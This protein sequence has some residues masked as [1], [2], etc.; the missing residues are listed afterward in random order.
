M[1]AFKKSLAEAQSTTPPGPARLS[2][3]F[4]PP[5]LTVT[6]IHYTDRHR[7]PDAVEKA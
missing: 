7:L 1:D 5:E 6:G 2:L 3:R 4:I